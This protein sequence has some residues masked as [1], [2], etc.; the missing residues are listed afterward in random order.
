M[1]TI[2]SITFDIYYIIYIILLTKLN[3]YF[4]PLRKINFVISL[5]KY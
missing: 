5:I 4:I 3:D 1:K 2:I